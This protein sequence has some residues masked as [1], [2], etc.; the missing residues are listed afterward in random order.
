MKLASFRLKSD[1]PHTN[2]RL[3]V[4]RDDAM[5][6]LSGFAPDVAPTNILAMLTDPAFGL[7]W[8]HAQLARAAIEPAYRVPKGLPI[9]AA[10]EYVTGITLLNDLTCR[11]TQKR[12]VVPGSH[13][14]RLSP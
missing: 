7:A 1:S 6:D 5:L 10:L 3:G 13:G 8:A 14:T 12:E 9:A 2:A 11:D 4:L